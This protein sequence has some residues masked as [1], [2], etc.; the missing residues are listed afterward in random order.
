MFTFYRKGVEWNLCY[1]ERISK[2]TTRYSWA[3]LL[4]DNIQNSF[5]SI[6]RKSIEPLA[7]IAET[8][9]LKRG[10]TIPDNAYED[11]LFDYKKE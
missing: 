8:Q 4:S 11:Y 5:V 3:P 10:I 7:L 9:E 6:D 2:F 1:N